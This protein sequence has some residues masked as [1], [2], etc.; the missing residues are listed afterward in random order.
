MDGSSVLTHMAPSETYNAQGRLEELIKSVKNNKDKAYA[1]ASLLVFGNGDG[2]G[3]PL[4]SMIERLNR[5][6]DVVLCS[7]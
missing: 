5:M 3:G 7:T 4:P 2:G 1:N 6:Q